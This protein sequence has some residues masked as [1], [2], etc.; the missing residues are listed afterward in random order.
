MTNGPDWYAPPKAG[1]PAAS[2]ST[3]PVDASSVEPAG[4]GVRAGARVLD[5][6]A[7]MG[8]AFVGGT[9]GS[10][11]LVALAAAGVAPADWQQRIAGLSAAGIGFGLVSSLL[12][13]ALSE[14]IGGASIGKAVLGLRVKSESLAP[15]GVGR[16]IV[17]NLGY[18]IDAFFFGLVAYSVMSKSPRQQR[19][20]DKWAGSVV[21]RAASLPRLRG[22]AWLPGIV[23]GCTAHIAV[24]I[25]SLVMRAL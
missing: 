11:L 16:G 18:Y 13:H 14:G 22:G 19:L 21:V 8:V 3:D 10:L 6:F 2:T 4:F 25:L 12:Y 7:V 17:R 9:V 20:G 1:G 5:I 24:T 23:L 15:C